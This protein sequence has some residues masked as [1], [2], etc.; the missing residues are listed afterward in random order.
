MKVKELVEL[1]KLAPQEL[2][3]YFLDNAYGDTPIKEVKRILHTLE[4]GYI[5]MEKEIIR[6]R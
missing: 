1:L 5:K 6:L 3:I 2:D 4:K